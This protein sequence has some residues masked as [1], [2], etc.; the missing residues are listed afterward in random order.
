[1]YVTPEGGTYGEDQTVLNTDEMLK[2]QEL[3]TQQQD[4]LKEENKEKDLYRKF[5]L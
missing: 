1:M 2:M 4:A 5:G 3:L